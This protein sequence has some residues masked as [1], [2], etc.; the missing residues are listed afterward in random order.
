MLSEEVEN[1][2][3]RNGVVYETGR[4]GGGGQGGEGKEREVEVGK[5]E[6]KIKRR[7]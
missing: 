5:R 1:V 6:G 7:E 3:V 2:G 4:E